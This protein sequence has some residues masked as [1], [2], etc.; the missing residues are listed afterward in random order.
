MSSGSVTS[1][2]VSRQVGLVSSGS[3]S[4]EVAVYCGLVRSGLGSS[5]LDTVVAVV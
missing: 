3:V 1:A 2:L 5:A 4:S